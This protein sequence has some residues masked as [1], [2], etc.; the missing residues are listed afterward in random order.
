MFYVEGI[1]DSVELDLEGLKLKRFSLMPTSQFIITLPA[2]TKKVLFVDYDNKSNA[3]LSE[4]EKNGNDKVVIFCKLQFA[5]TSGFLIN[6]LN[7]L[8]F[9]RSNVRVCV[10]SEKDEQNNV[11]ARPNSEDVLE[12]HLI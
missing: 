3:Y 10:R 1:I 6:F 11:I 5:H 2:G 8:K 4:A 7:Q 9:N 12:V